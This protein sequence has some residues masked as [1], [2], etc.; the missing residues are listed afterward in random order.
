MILPNECEN[1]PFKNSKILGE[2]EDK[3]DG[4]LKSPH[5]IFEEEKKKKAENEQ[6]KKPGDRP[7][8]YHVICQDLI[9]DMRVKELRKKKEK[10]DLMKRQAK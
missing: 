3:D 7:H 6:A 1:H 8:F 4:K 9:K 5:M 2:L 10:I